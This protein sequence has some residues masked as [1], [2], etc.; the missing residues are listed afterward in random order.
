MLTTEPAGM[1]GMGSLDLSN[2]TLPA[3]TLTGSSAADA[4]PTSNTG[5]SG[6]AT[7]DQVAASK[8]E[9]LGP[10]DSTGGNGE[11][12]VDIFTDNTGTQHITASDL[13]GNE[14]WSGSLRP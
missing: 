14:T 11:R 6:C 5:K 4:G 3:G 13:N 1:G 8:T 2:I 9:T 7:C 12:I 10:A